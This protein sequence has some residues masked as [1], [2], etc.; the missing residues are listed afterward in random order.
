MIEIGAKEESTAGFKSKFVKL[1]QIDQNSNPTVRMEN[2]CSQSTLQTRAKTEHYKKKCEIPRD[3]PTENFK[4]PRDNVFKKISNSFS[5]GK[6][7]RRKI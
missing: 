1:I 2:T 3:F 6:R 4:F 7:I 5:E